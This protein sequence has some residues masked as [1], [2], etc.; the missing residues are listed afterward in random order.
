LP[1]PKGDYMRV[2]HMILKGSNE[3]IGLALASKA[4][5]EYGIRLAQYTDTSYARA[6]LEYFKRNWQEMDESFEPVSGCDE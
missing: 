5:D 2:R 1:P 4:K 3:E 6:R